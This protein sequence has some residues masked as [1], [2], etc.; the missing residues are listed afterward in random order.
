MSPRSSGIIV[1]EPRLV[2][3][4]WPKFNPAFG[5]GSGECASLVNIPKNEGADKSG[6]V[7][8]KE[9][10]WM[11][12]WEWTGTGKEEIKWGG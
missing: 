12:M 4:N 3:L 1:S 11:W 7:A 10:E 2:S 5:S 8:G 9:A 6:C